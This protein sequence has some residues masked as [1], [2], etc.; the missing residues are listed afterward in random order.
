MKT[1]LICAGVLIATAAQAQSTNALSKPSKQELDAA[2][3]RHLT[4][5]PMA[6]KEPK[7]NQITVGKNTYSGLVV[8]VTRTDN[9]LQLLNPAAP[10]PYGSFEDTVVREPINRKVVGVKLFAIDF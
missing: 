5:T 8:L 4:E 7:L 3:V 10:V 1:V 9:P 6:L 2:V